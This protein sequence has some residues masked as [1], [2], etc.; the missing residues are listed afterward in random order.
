MFR[1]ASPNP[2]PN[3]NLDPDPNPNITL[4]LI[5]LG[6]LAQAGAECMPV[7]DIEGGMRWDKRRW[8]ELVEQR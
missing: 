5:G 8:G 2:N 4:T 6:A 7:G 1:V 3:P